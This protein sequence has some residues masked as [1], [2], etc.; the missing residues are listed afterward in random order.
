MSTYKQVLHNFRVCLPAFFEGVKY[1][2]VCM[3]SPELL[4]KE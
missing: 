4:K 2:C 3:F 1:M